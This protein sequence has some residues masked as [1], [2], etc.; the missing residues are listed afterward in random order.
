MA[1]CAEPDCDE[2]AAVQLFV[3]WGDDRAV[4]TGHARSIAQQDGALAAPLPAAH[5]DGQ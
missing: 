3:P 5:A 4:C 2:P 1:T